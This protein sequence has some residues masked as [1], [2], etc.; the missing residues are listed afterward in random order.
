MLIACISRAV[1]GRSSLTRLTLSAAVSSKTACPPSWSSPRRARWRAASCA[2]LPRSSWSA[3][4]TM[5]MT[6]TIMTR[7]RP[8]TA[9]SKTDR[10]W[11]TPS[12]R[13]RVLAS[14]VHPQPVHTLVTLHLTRLTPPQKKQYTS[15]V[16]LP[17][18]GTPFAHM[19]KDWGV[20]T[21]LALGPRN[22]PPP[23]LSPENR[24]YS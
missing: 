22:G 4:R 5:M 13:S 14:H 2:G 7:R 10:R 20:G 23:P 18:D 11:Q 6:T 12:T 15:F 9:A 16:A 1:L 3:G 8:I 19:R 17:F 24:T 21:A